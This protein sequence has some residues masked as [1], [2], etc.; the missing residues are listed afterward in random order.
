MLVNKVA[1]SHWKKEMEM[2]KWK[3]MATSNCL[4]SNILQNIFICVQ[5]KKET[6]NNIFIFGWTKNKQKTNK[7]WIKN[8]ID[9][10]L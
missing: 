10:V 2:I 3:S 9:F 4:V 7:Q 6:H 5:Q 8:S 1:G